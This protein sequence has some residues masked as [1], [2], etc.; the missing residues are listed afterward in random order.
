MAPSKKAALPDVLSPKEPF[1][2]QSRE[3]VVARYESAGGQS[4]G[5]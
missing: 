5:E 2:A 3:G 1:S 4:E